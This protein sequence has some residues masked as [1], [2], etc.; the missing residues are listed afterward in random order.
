MQTTYIAFLRAI[1]VGGHTVTMERLRGLFK[2]MGFSQ[3]RSYIQT[4]NIFF[5]ADRSEDRKALTAIIESSLTKALGYSVGVVVRTVEEVKMAVATDPFR[6]IEVTP[7]MRLCVL[8][9][10]APLPKNLSLPYFSPKQDFHILSF[11]EGEVFLVLYQVHG[12][13]GNPSAFLEKTFGVTA[14]TRFYGTTLKILAA[15][16]KEA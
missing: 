1:N 9:V 14:T 6:G 4:G 3:V 12:K 13:T 2:E 10:S 7:D 5:V 8:F 16:E 11:T 15:A